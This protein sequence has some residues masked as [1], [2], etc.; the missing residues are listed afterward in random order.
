M[1]MNPVTLATAMKTPIK[2]AHIAVG[3]A[4]NAALDTFCQALATA[5]ASTVVAHIAASGVVAVV[6]TCPAGAGAGTG[7]VT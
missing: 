6:T 3:A 1:A 7:T 2:A 5:I 4:D